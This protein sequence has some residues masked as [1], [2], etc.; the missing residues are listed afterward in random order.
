MC[1][2]VLAPPVQ[3]DLE[4]DRARRPFDDSQAKAK[5]SCGPLSLRLNW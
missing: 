5:P 3:L 4:S 1:I 2:W